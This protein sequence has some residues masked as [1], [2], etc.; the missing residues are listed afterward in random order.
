MTRDPRSWSSRPYL[1]YVAVR[2]SIGMSPNAV[3]Q[4]SELEFERVLKRFA[5]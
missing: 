5:V 3:R 2:R 1:F 4:L